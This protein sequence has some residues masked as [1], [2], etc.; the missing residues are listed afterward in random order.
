MESLTSLV[1]SSLHQPAF[2]SSTSVS[3]VLGVVAV[4]KGCSDKIGGHFRA[5]CGR[6]R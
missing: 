2:L 3:Y 1:L 5:T 4:S 6:F